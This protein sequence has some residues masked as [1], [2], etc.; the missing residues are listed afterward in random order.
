MLSDD[1]MLGCFL[2]SER[3][4]ATALAKPPMTAFQI[5]QSMCV[6]VNAKS[7]YSLAFAALFDT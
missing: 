1:V 5:F 7:I 4:R 3:L 2:H 6:E